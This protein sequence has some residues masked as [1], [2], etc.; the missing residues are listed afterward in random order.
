M[1]IF[2]NSHN[3]AQTLTTP[4]IFDRYGI[5]Y[6]LLLHNEEQKK[7]YLKNTL[8][9]PE[10][11]VVA[12]Y[13][14]GMTGIRNF[15][16]ETM[17]DDGE[18]YAIIDDNITSFLAVKD[19]FYNE[20]ELDVK[21]NPDFYKNV[22]EN[23]V[24][25]LRMLEIFEESINEAE[26][27]GAKLVGF[28]SNTNFFFRGRKWRDVGYVIGKTQLI[29]KTDLR[30]DLNV[31]AMDDY[32]WTAQNIE[33]FGRVLINNYFVAIKKHYAKG[34][35]GTYAERLPKKIKDSK[36]LVERF[37]GLFRYNNKKTAEE[38]AELAIRFTDLKQVERWR[39]YMRSKSKSR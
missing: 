28:A 38:K 31:D 35:I 22:Y 10:K 13:P 20:K 7:E 14:V 33:K 9:S 6:I 21:G 2:I 1:K 8:V 3:R 27:R 25:P 4:M 26:K 24:T 34:G 16:L 15:L 36:Y 5:D 18:W 30:Y 23:E 32:L 39:A 37:D 17:V 11:I 19:E 29:K 12:N